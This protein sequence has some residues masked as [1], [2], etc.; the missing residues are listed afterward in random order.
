MAGLKELADTT[1][2]AYGIRCTFDCPEPVLVPS[3]FTA[4]HIYR[5]AQEAIH[6]SVEHGHAQRISIELSAES[7]TARMRITDDGVGMTEKGASHPGLGVRVM[8]YRA[9]SVGGTLRLEPG[10]SGGVEVVCEWPEAGK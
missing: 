6:N 10:K 4:G 1:E 3:T 2:R 7:D 8:R 5:I 9:E